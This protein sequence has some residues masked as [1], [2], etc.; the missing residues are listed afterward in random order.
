MAEPLKIKSS[1]SKSGPGDELRQKAKRWDKAKDEYRQNEDGTR[2][3]HKMGYATEDNSAI[4]YPTVFPKDRAGTK[5]HN[6]KDWIE[7]DHKAAADNAYARG[8]I[9]K[10][11]SEQN[12]KK[13]SEGE[14][15]KN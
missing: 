5:S 9:Y 13:W 10:F 15:K 12:A 14:Y 11:K 6:P 1:E 8:E 3:T 4:A 7:L 2:S